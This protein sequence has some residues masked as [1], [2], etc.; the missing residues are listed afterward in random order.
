MSETFQTTTV[1]TARRVRHETKMR[2]LQVR[3]VSRLTPK[4][5]PYC[6]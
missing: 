3:E 5:G 6:C 2:L 1:R 4:N